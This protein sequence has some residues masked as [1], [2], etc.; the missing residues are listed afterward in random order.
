[1]RKPFMTIASVTL[2]V[3]AILTLVLSASDG[4]VGPPI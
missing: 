3:A 1:M 4:F 2:T